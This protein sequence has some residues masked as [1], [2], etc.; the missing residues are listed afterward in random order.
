MNMTFLETFKNIS[1]FPTE[2][3]IRLESNQIKRQD[4]K[5]VEPYIPEVFI[6]TNIKDDIVWVNTGMGYLWFIRP[7]NYKKASVFVPKNKVNKMYLSALKIK[8]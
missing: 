1:A 5:K 7:Y 4:F 8:L 3:K 6:P 2:T